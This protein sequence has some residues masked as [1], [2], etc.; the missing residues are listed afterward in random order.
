M[1]ITPTS[2]L[3][4]AGAAAGLGGLCY[5]FV[6][7]FHPAN[8]PASVTTTRWE[9]VHVVAC[10]M[11]LFALLGLAGVYAR[12]AVKSGWLGLVGYVLLSAWF[13]LIM[14]F[15]FV[16]AF[17]LPRVAKT[18]PTLVDAWMKMFNGG[19]S[20]LDLGVLPTLWTLSAPLYIGGGVLFGIATFRARV[21]P[22][23]AAALLALGTGT[24]PSRRRAL[25][26][27]AAKD[28]DPYGTCDRVAGLCADDGA[29]QPSRRALL[30]FTGHHA[31]V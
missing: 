17:I 7:I 28:R 9:M 29:A 6:G 18:K 19:T 24:S 2:L 1:K 12:Q 11:C 31:V 22:R 10:V 21:L 14:G 26:Y 13:V 27:H 3:R 15:S 23:G 8:A 30:S 4:V 20:Q 5:V 25:A 16:E